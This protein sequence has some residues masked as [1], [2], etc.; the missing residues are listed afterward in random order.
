[1]KITMIRPPHRH[2]PYEPPLGITSIAAVLEM[3]GYSVSI[4]DFETTNIHTKDRI[5]KA[6]EKE[7]PDVVG[8][9]FFTY[10]RF[11]AL[12]V[13]DAAK[14]LGIFVV[15]GGLHVTFD[16]ENT[17]RSVPGIDVAVLG[18][19]EETMRELMQAID[20]G[21]S[22]DTI[23]GIA[24]RNGDKI[25]IN[26]PRQL[27]TNLDELPLPAYHL[28][29]MEKYPYHAIMGSRGCPYNCIFCASPGFWR[30]IVRFRSYKLVVDEI[31]HLINNYGN[32]YFDFK[33]DTLFLN[34]EWSTNLFNEIIRRNIKIRWDALG[35]VN[36]RDEEIFKLMKKAGCDIIRFGVETGSERIMKIINKNITKEDVRSA[37]KMVKRVSIN[38]VGT[39]FMLGHPTETVEDMEETCQFSIELNADHYSFKPTDIYPG[40]A[41]FDLAVNEGLLPNNFNWFEKGIYKK[42]FLTYD[43][44]PSYETAR[45]SRKILEDM[46]KRFYIRA[47]FARLFNLESL[48]NFRHFIVYTGL[49]LK[50]KNKNELIVFFEEIIR[51][52]KIKRTLKKRI[53]GLCMFFI[54]IVDRVSKKIGLKKHVK[55]D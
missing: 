6:L 28:L 49:G 27:I 52:L 32:K 45:F 14:E 29:P 7:S 25:I 1:M 33:D 11:D 30:R 43:D 40:T 31:E 50:P 24:Y 51:E 38:S 3:E 44:V 47:F 26:P 35:R 53:I 18:E 8:V 19:G 21:N 41:L 54:Y 9:S 46:A 5:K 10:D 12:K 17:L 23:K 13:I 48:G 55:F 39:L 16:S 2:N 37:V 22:L 34:K 20:T 42:G 4:I 15:A 36:I